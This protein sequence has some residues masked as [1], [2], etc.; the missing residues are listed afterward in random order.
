MIETLRWLR[1]T[2]ATETTTAIPK[3]WQFKHLFDID[4][5]SFFT[6]NQTSK[7]DD[8]LLSCPLIEYIAKTQPTSC[9][10]LVSGTHIAILCR[11]TDK[12]HLPVFFMHELLEHIKAMG[13]HRAELLYP[14]S[15]TTLYL[16]VFSVQ[17]LS[18]HGL[19]SV[20]FETWSTMRHTLSQIMP[21]MSLFLHNDQFASITTSFTVNPATAEKLLTNYKRLHAE[22]RIERKAT[23]RTHGATGL[24]SGMT[25]RYVTGLHDKNP[26]SSSSSSSSRPAKRDM[27]ALPSIKPVIPRKT[28][29]RPN[30]KNPDQLLIDDDDATSSSSS[31]SS[32]SL[33]E[34]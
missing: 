5:Q 12:I 25:R 20:L 2:S 23:G 3:S 29:G 22:A 28:A 32:S 26:P 30:P 34:K 18:K 24:E 17:D 21:D 27:S 4:P 11:D 19:L 16:E 10:D 31:R 14:V 13:I 7:F 9:S 1:V 33:N 15:K 6:C 8:S